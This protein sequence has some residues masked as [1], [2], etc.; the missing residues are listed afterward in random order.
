LKHLLGEEGVRFDR[1]RSI[2]KT[3]NVL[4]I[5]F[6]ERVF[7]C[8]W[9]LFFSVCFHANFLLVASVKAFC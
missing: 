9:H 3:G 1:K 6:W 7:H 2:L 5:C 4:T 8:D